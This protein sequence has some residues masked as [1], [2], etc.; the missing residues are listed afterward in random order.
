MIRADEGKITEEDIQEGNFGEI[1]KAVS[2]KALE[3]WNPESS[4]FTAIRTKFELR[5]RLPIDPDLFDKLQEYNFE[6]FREGNELVVNLPVLTISFDNAW[7]GDSYLDKRMYLIAPYLDEEEA[8]QLKE[9]LVD[10]TKEPKK[11]GTGEAEITLSEEELK[12]LE[13][14]LEEVEEEKPRKKR[15]KRK[16]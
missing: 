6:M 5:Y 9:Y 14:G 8:K 1:A 10:A 7:L 16:K 11:V 12:R 4:D 3:E 2:K 15:R 13:E